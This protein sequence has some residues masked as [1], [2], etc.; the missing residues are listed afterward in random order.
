[1]G[2]INKSIFLDS[3]YFNFMDITYRLAQSSLFFWI[4]LLRNFILTGFT[5]SFCIL[6]E[7]VNEILSGNGLSIRQLFHRKSQQYKQYKAL[8][9][10]TVLLMVYLSAFTFLPFP[11]FIN[12]QISSFIKYSSLY[13]LIVFL[14]VTI[15]INW[16]IIELNL[17]LGKAIFYAFY[18]M[19]R[20]FIRSF[21]LLVMLLII[22]FLSVK[23]IV[24]LIFFAPSILAMVTRFIIQGLY[25]N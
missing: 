6:L 16:N 22:I 11:E 9:V 7:S 1:M 15:Y 18:L 13:L 20:H 4:Y 21:L 23:N 19:I 14:I 5:L 8:S 24:F 17:S 10:I 25:K 3:K 2:F 12:V